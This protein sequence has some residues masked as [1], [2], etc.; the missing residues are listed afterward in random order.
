MVIREKTNLW[1]N[2]KKK[3]AYEIGHIL[4]TVDFLEEKFFRGKIG[5]EDLD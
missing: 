3:R 2:L 4:N 5:M 1:I